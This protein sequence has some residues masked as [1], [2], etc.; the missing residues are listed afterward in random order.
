MRL[1]IWELDKLTMLDFSERKCQNWQESTHPHE[2]AHNPYP[3]PVVHLHA[4][5]PVAR[6]A[7]GQAE[8]QLPAQQLQYAGQEARARARRVEVGG[9][10]PLQDAVAQDDATQVAP[11]LPDVGDL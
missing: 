10:R 8:V 4:V 6:R 9:G 5:L 1:S 3:G 2:H 7:R 11:A